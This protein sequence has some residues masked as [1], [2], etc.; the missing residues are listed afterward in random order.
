MKI[1]KYIIAMLLG[2]LFTLQSCK[3][4]GDEYYVNPNSPTTASAAALNTTIQVSTLNSYEGDLAR[5]SSEMIQQN[6]GVSNQHA[7]YQQYNFAESVFNNSW[8][9]IYQALYTAKTLKDLYGGA[10]PYYN[11]IANV[12]MAMN[13]SLLTDLFGEIPYSEALQGVDNLQPKFDSQEDV[14]LGIMNQLNEAIANFSAA[15]EDN[16]FLPG[17]D[18]LFYAGDIDMWIKLTHSLKARYMNRLSKKGMYDGTAIMNEL[19]MGIT[20]AADDMMAPHGAGNAQ[21]QWWAFQNGR[22]QYVLACET[23]VDKY[24]E[25]ATDMRLEYIFAEADSTGVR[26]GSPV[27]NV[28]TSVSPW[29]DYLAASTSTPVPMVTY[30]EMKFIEAEVL[31]AADPLAASMA[32]NEAIKA[33]CELI[34]GGAYDGTDIAIYTA[35]DT[36]LESVMTEKWLALFGQIEAYNDYRRTGYPMLTPNSAGVINTIPGRFKYPSDERNGNPNMPTN[37]S[38]ADPVW[39]AL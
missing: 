24:K 36:D 30:T 12:I 37:V 29:G 5:I 27:D 6:A 13:W 11:G 39:W 19:A 35:V 21:N 26:L 16:A 10:S 38:I 9:Q 28:S 3:E 15:P 25:R 1:T 22:A 32:L 34:T 17:V 4:K 2:A 8:G 14:Y 31:A 23:Y 18:D 33:S 7:A 20:S